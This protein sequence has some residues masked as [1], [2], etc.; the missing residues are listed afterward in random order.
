[1]A[2]RINVI[3]SS[4]PGPFPVIT[5][6]PI[7]SMKIDFGSIPCFCA[8]STSA[9]ARFVLDVVIKATIALLHGETPN[10]FCKSHYFRRFLCS[11]KFHSDWDLATGWVVVEE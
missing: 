5:L 4:A 8:R 9:V 1:M 10:W 3:M 7:G 2:Y 6:E 11:Q